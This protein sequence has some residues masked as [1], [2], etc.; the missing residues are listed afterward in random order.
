MFLQHRQ[1]IL[2]NYIGDKELFLVSGY[3]SFAASLITFLTI[4]ETTTLDL[5]EIDKQWHNILGGET[6]EGPAVTP[7]HLSFYERNHHRFCCGR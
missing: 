4:P 3:A 2:F 6:Y 5:Y 1:S 7:K